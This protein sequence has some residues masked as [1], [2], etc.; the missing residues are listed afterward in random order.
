MTEAARDQRP[1]PAP[2]EG[3]PFDTERAL[4]T[5]RSLCVPEMGGRA[6]GSAGHERAKAFLVS[7]LTAAGLS[8][9]LEHFAISGVL[10]LSAPPYCGVTGPGQARDLVH[11]AEFAEHPRSG[12]MPAPVTALASEEALPGRWAVVRGSSQ[13]A[14]FAELADSYAARGVVGLLVG[15][16]ADASG[17]LTKRVQGPPPVRLPVVA[18]LPELLDVVAGQTVTAHVPLERMPAVGVNI[19][20]TLPGRAPDAPPILLTAHYDGVGSDPGRHF[21]CAGDNASGTAV[22]CEVARVLSRNDPLERPVIFA[23]LDGEEMGTLGS[24]AHARQLSERKLRPDVLN[25]DMAGKFNGK[26]AVELGPADPVPSDLIAALD[27]SGRRLGLPLYAAPVASDNRR[28]AAAGFPSAGVGLGAAHYHSPLDSPERI[29]AE[30][31]HKAGQL[32]LATVRHL[33]ARG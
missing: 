19:V 18:L 14:D 27:A 26:V 10:R 9:A 29:E 2:G 13:G 12:P 8:P 24:G 5:L 7:E 31:L 17:Y 28:Y 21:P 22:V 3:E 30:A 15:Q 23:L 16:H 33:A 6:P 4:A 20:A 32:T 1:S 25:I 11:R